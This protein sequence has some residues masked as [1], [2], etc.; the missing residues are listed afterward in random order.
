MVVVGCLGT[1]VGYSCGD[2]GASN[3]VNVHMQCLHDEVSSVVNI[4]T[5]CSDKTFEANTSTKANAEA[6]TAVAVMQLI[7][8][9]DILAAKAG[10]LWSD[11]SASGQEP[12]T[13]DNA[14]DRL[15]LRCERQTLTRLPQT[16]G[17][18]FTI[19]TYNQT[20]RQ[21]LARRDGQNLARRLPGSALLTYRGDG[22]TIY[23]QGQTCVDDQV[24]RY[25]IS[26][27]LPSAIAVC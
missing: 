23:G 22:H 8:E 7:L 9:D 20:L 27:T 12:I 26:L 15:F 17:V 14:P 4:S 25:L 1:W 3:G 11:T 2:I 19:R 16:G 13:L 5:C 21:V 24:N 6:A 18:L 10:T